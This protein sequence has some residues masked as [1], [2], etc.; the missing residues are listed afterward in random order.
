M[1][2]T[3]PQ[4]GA[5]NFFVS[6]LSMLACCSGMC[7]GKDAKVVRRVARMLSD[8]FA[9]EKYVATDVQAGLVLATA[10]Q[11]EHWDA[12]HSHVREVSMFQ[13]PFQAL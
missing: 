10:W 5:Y 11:E 1:V 13:L 9:S 3:E 6:R 4:Q 12:Y 8:V 7:S 2:T